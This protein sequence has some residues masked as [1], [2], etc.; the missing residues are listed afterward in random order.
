M[1]CIPPIFLFPLIEQPEV[2]E[3]ILTHLGLWAAPDH[4]PPVAGHPLPSSRQWVVAA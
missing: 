1:M 2:I 3:T 4:S